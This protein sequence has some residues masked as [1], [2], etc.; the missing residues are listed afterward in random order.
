MR[1]M[2]RDL[3]NKNVITF[4]VDENYL[5]FAKILVN[6][7]IKNSP[8]INICGRFINCSDSDLNW[9]ADKIT[10]IK[11]N[12]E[13]SKKRNLKTKQGLYATDDFVYTN[14]TEVKPIKLFYSE[15]IAYCS[16]I[17]FDTIFNLLKNDVKNVL[18]IDV[19]SIIR[20]NLESL[21][22]NLN[23]N[24]FCFFKD[25]PYTEQLDN[26]RL[27][28]ANFLYHGG[29]IGVNNNNKTLSIIEKITN[30]VKDD[31]FDWDID[32]R[33]LPDIINK[34][35]KILN[36]KKTYKDEDLD[37]YSLLWSGSGKTKFNNDR[38]ID[39]CKKYK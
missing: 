29:L 26:N 33:V 15:L 39:E 11:D 24:D 12:K 32:E 16:N 27:E 4:T 14:K 21:F 22:D 38:Y 3:V 19:D 5:P 34:S 13:L 30:T 7:I 8:D 2:F 31:I 6:S 36:V 35:K 37:S 28:G 17:K 20:G 25:K 10:I 1:K 9:F 18:Y 23:K